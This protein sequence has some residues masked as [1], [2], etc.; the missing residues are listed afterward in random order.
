MSNFAD[1]ID[2]AIY[3]YDYAPLLYLNLDSFIL[4]ISFE[5]LSL[6]KKS[7]IYIINFDLNKIDMGPGP[8]DKFQSLL[9]MWH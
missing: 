6:C 9:T 4:L 2:S 3:V 7:N 8:L 1:K 5:I